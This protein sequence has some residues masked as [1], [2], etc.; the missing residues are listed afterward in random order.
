[1]ALCRNT[2]PDIVSLCTPDAT[3][4]E[5]ARSLLEQCAP[6][7]L[8]IEKPLAMN[9]DEGQVLQELA[10][11][12]GC[13]I[14]VNYS[15][16]FSPAFQLMAHDIQTGAYGKPLRAV[17]WYGK[18][19]LHNGGHAIDL[20]RF[21]FGEPL[22][23]E[24]HGTPLWGEVEKDAS[25]EAEFMFDDGLHAFMHPFDE[26]MATVFEMD[27]FCEKGRVRF[28]RGGQT[29]TFFDR[30]TTE[31]PGAKYQ[32]FYPKPATAQR[33]EFVSPMGDCLKHAVNNIVNHLDN[34]EKLLCSAEDGI[35]VLRW[36]DALRGR[37]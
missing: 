16:R 10:K 35:A 5:M 21:W 13:S 18:G 25:L 4:F 34:G 15:R 3:H 6:K 24:T 1:M 26:R 28:E 23:A 20:F 30:Q 7:F 12:K 17:L 36:V 2:N 9:Q 8:F 29:W 27:L 19:L 32:Y 22:K 11:K 14:G 31:A 33:P 37:S